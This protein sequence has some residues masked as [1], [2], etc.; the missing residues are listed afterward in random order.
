V[1]GVTRVCGYDRPD[2]PASHSDPTPIRTAQ[3]VVDDLRAL[4]AAA[5]EPGPYVLVGHSLGGLYVQLFAYRHPDEV[6][7]LV[8]VDPTPEGFAER[9]DILEAA[10]W[11]TPPPEPVAPDGVLPPTAC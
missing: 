9:L 6:A 10:Q 5:G 1:A 7:G 4:L 3:E 11:G 2:A 8:L